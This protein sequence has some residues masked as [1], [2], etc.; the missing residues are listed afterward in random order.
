MRLSK[1]NHEEY[2][3][4][5]EGRITKLENILLE[6]NGYVRNSKQKPVFSIFSLDEMVRNVWSDLKFMEQ[7]QQVSVEIKIDKHIH[8]N[9]DPDKWKMIISNLISN[10]IKYHDLKRSE[11][12]LRIRAEITYDHLELSFEDNGQGVSKEHQDKIFDM[13][14]RANEASTGSGLGLFL[15]KKML[16]RLGGSISIESELGQGTK[17]KIKTPSSLNHALITPEPI[18]SS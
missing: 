11:P 10:S 14:Y 12:Y 7:A 15:V 8:L 2:I 1:D 17:V 5:M 6:I 4:M 16:D 9:S 13:F 18:S 3:T